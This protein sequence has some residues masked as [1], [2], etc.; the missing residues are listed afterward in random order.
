[1]LSRHKEFTCGS[2]RSQ[3]LAVHQLPQLTIDIVALHP[4]PTACDGP[5]TRRQERAADPDSVLMLALVKVKP[6]SAASNPPELQPPAQTSLPS[7]EDR[8][9]DPKRDASISAVILWI[10]SAA[11]KLVATICSKQVKLTKAFP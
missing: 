6:D 8:S 3:L 9:E 7:L 11:I 4:L 5:L 2:G 10:S 1:M